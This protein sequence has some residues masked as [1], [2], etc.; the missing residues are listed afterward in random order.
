MLSRPL[1]RLRAL[2]TDDL[3]I[4]NSLLS[5]LTLSAIAKTVFLSQPSISSRLRKLE[6]VFG[7]PLILKHGRSVI[8]SDHGVGI[9]QRCAT[10]LKALEGG[11]S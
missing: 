7:S 3:L 2:D 1:T 10:A 6:D 5:G 9:A 4:M 8:L 11:I